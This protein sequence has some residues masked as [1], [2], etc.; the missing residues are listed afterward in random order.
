MFSPLMF[1]GLHV[2]S[3][4]VYY[5]FVFLASIVGLFCELHNLMAVHRGAG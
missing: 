2:V 4:E 5:V 3:T 1:S